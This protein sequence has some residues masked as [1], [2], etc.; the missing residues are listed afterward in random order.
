[1][2]ILVFSAAL[3]SPSGLFS[4]VKIT[5][6]Q[7]LTASDWITAAERDGFKPRKDDGSHHIYK[8]PDDGR[9]VLFIYH[10]LGETFGPKTIK[11]I[12]KNTG[13]TEADLK[14]LGILK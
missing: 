4:N 9:R 2:K 12:L 7:N 10:N 3:P 13:W 6:L 1:M 5:L 11:K 14:R 8:H